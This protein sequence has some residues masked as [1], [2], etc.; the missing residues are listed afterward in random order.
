[1]NQTEE[2][3]EDNIRRQ[4][5]ALGDEVD[6]IEHAAAKVRRVDGFTNRGVAASGHVVAVDEPK[7]FGGG[8]SAA[9]PAELL[10][11][12]I[13]A[14]LSVSL[15]VHAA[16]REVKL[17]HIDVAIAGTMN[18]A[19]FFRP[20]DAPGGGLTQLALVVTLTTTASDAEARSLLDQALL[21][22]PVLRS[23]AVRPD[24]RL[25]RA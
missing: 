21:A 12:A 9:D 8:G 16:L 4:S 11:I 25:V 23:L 13:G 7:Q 24:V 15:T 17:D 20:T 1:M 6:L 19:R 14:S 10:L 22:S 18:G 2:C 5:D 3:L